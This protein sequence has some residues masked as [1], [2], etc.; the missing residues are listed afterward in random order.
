M[1]LHM[2]VVWLSRLGIQVL[3]T[4][5]SFM[6]VWGWVVRVVSGAVECSLDGA[7]KRCVG[8]A[9]CG[10][11][12]W[13]VRMM[14]MCST[15]CTSQS[16]C[17]ALSA[18]LDGIALRTCRNQWPR[19]LAYELSRACSLIIDD[20]IAWIDLQIHDILR[21]RV[22]LCT[23]MIQDG[24]LTQPTT[25]HHF[26]L[27]IGELLCIEGL[28]RILIIICIFTYRIKLLPCVFGV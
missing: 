2:V 9:A 28:W 17:A 12:E 10:L 8:F 21:R 25:R 13:D 23:P 14:S 20:I 6:A 5:D 3:L 4:W 27:L 22:L 1:E 24:L 26:L 7:L 19:S 11:Q 16:E 15:A 18:V